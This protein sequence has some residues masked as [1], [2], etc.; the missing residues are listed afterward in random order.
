MV[1]VAASGRVVST[2]CVL[3]RDYASPFASRAGI[4][5]NAGRIAYAICRLRSFPT[6]R[7]MRF[8]ASV[9]HSPALSDRG[10][11]RAARTGRADA[12]GC[13]SHARAPIAGTAL[14]ATG[15]PNRNPGCCRYERSRFPGLCHRVR[16]R[17]YRIRVAYRG[18]NRL[19]ALSTGHPWRTSCGVAHSY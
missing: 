9:D 10:R 16:S 17:G 3:L 4:V 2:A 1:G 8:D 11:S 5:T 18:A 6:C 7:G 13:H 12:P 14:G 19:D 15:C